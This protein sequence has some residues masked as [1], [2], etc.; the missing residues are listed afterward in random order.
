MLIMLV[1]SARK[2]LPG[3]PHYSIIGFT[4]LRALEGGMSQTQPLKV[5]V[6]LRNVFDRLNRALAK[7]G[8]ALHT[9]HKHP[10]ARPSPKA[11]DHFLNTLD[12]EILCQMSKHL[13]FWRGLAL[14]SGSL[15]NIMTTK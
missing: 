7:E 4:R 12:L 6:P 14:R 3:R 1:F 5:Q 8:K 13:T 2:R 9:G 15:V 11:M 10:Y